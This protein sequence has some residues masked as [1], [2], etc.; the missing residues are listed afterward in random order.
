MSKPVVEL[1]VVNGR[2]TIRG[3]CDV[4]AAAEIEAWLASF[5]DAPISVDL[6]SV[7]FLDSSGLRALLNARRRIFEQGRPVIAVT[8]GGEVIITPHCAAPETLEGQRLSA[9]LIDLI[10]PFDTEEGTHGPDLRN[11]A[12]SCESCRASSQQPPTS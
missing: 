4:A 3:E 6:S 1:L 12:S 11:R 9:D 7:T 2:P 5:G 8:R 10:A